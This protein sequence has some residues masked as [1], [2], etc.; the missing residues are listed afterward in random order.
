MDEPDAK[1]LTDQAMAL[2]GAK[3][4]NEAEALCR[5]VLQSD[6]ENADALYA[7]AA[8]EQQ[9]RRPAEAEQYLLRAVRSAPDAFWNHMALGDVRAALG[10][11]EGALEAYRS[12][13]ELD[14][15][16]V[17]ACRALGK[18][19]FRLGRFDES[20][21]ELSRLTRLRGA[22]AEDVRLLER[23]HEIALSKGL[24]Q[25]ANAALERA[26]IIST[27]Q[28]HAPQRRDELE[29]ELERKLAADQNDL[30]ALCGL[31]D[32]KVATGDLNAALT[33]YRRIIDLMPDVSQHVE[34]L[35]MTS[36]YDPNQSVADAF[37]GHRS[38]GERFADRL[39]IGAPPFAQ[40]H[41]PGR[42]PLRIGYISPDFRGHAAAQFLLPL[43]R[44]HSP[45]E[46]EVSCFSDTVEPD[47]ITDEFKRRAAHWHDVVGQSAQQVFELVRAEQIDVLIDLAGHTAGNRLAVFARRAAPVQISYLGYCFTTGMRAMDAVVGDEITDPANDTQPY[48]ERAVL[49]LPRGF[50]CFAP[51]A[52]APE[53]NDLPASHDNGRITFGSLHAAIK[54]NDRVLDL[55]CRLLRDVP[56]SKLLLA[57]NTLFG[58]AAERLRQRL[59]ARGVGE[60][61]FEIR[62][63]PPVKSHWSFYHLIDVSLDVQPWSGHTTS[64]ESTWMGVPFV[65][66]LG[67]SH[68]GRMAASAVTHAGFGEWVA[69]DEDDYVR[70]A[71]D[72]AS[73]VPRLAELRR[74]MRDR[75]A[76]SQLCDGATFTASWESAIRE[77]WR[78]WCAK[79]SAG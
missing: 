75:M 65:T 59:L 34:H 70:I 52:N 55:W 29:V 39:S 18:L 38:W 5:T 72:L 78:A 79:G 56:N 40:G 46:V 15:S 77:L 64:C 12:A 67:R 54:L 7:M 28:L 14:P 19:L 4:F 66:M 44:N 53:P 68:A 60:D 1:S 22:G 35:L 58:C 11:T 2:L 37:E 25:L 74:T 20:L 30:E 50:A 21:L 48:T 71:R 3:R 24:T 9:R 17:H 45:D 62:H 32:I 42:R 47:A 8:V 31:T 36:L 76:K 6:P 33:L 43:F 61:R 41:D 13:S 63:E 73:D 16:S 10:N 69:R 57:R 27:R 23:F 51:P 49:R 26:K